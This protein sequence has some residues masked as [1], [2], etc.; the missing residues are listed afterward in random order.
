MTKNMMH[1]KLQSIGWS[2]ESRGIEKW[3]DLIRD[4]IQDFIVS[5]LDIEALLVDGLEDEQDEFQ[6]DSLEHAI[7]FLI[8]KALIGARNVK[9]EG[10]I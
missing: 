3:V 5:N 10:D 9:E 7:A 1:D 8:A 2:H 6:R 4:D